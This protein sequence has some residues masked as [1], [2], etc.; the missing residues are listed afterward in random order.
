MKSKIFSQ[1]QNWR[2]TLLREHTPKLNSVEN[3]NN[4]LVEEFQENEEATP[5]SQVEQQVSNSPF[6]LEVEE[7][8]T[9]DLGE[10]EDPVKSYY[11]RLRMLTFNTIVQVCFVPNRK[12]YGSTLKEL[13]WHQQDYDS[14]KQDA[15]NEI[16]MYWRLSGTS[17]KEA[18]VALY[19]P[20]YENSLVL[21]VLNHNTLSQSSSSSHFLDES[22]NS[23]VSEEENSSGGEVSSMVVGTVMRHVDSLSCFHD[24]QFEEEADTD[25]E[26]TSNS[27]P[28]SS[29]RLLPSL[30]Q[31]SNLCGVWMDPD[32]DN[33]LLVS[34]SM[35]Y[36]C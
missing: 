4:E 35:D 26:S 12:D 17:A 27:N 34:D 11:S 24:G 15:V 33:D 18:I 23:C 36:D 8:S 16:R 1:K 7:D 22:T 30:Q 19:Q 9:E 10:C 28:E 3:Q 25:S 32:G 14:F 6:S 29:T 20:E 5:L 13:Y 2:R 31:N 21:S